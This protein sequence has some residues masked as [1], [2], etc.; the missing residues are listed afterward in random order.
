MKN[1][2]DGIIRNKIQQKKEK[3]KVP[4]KDERKRFFLKALGAA[5]L[6]AFIFSMFPKKAQA[7]IFGSSMRAPDPIGLKNSS[8]VLINPA[9]S[10]KQDEIITEL[11]SFTTYAN[12]AVTLTNASTAYLLPS[13]E[14]ASRKSI[15]IYNGSD[16]DMYIGSSSVTSSN[17]ALLPAGGVMNIDAESGVYATCASAG[18][19]IRV[20]EC[21]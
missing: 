14:Q 21:K 15:Q 17:G 16:T 20:M 10:E 7:L 8:G 1:S 6:S 13:S 19:I 3:G 4:V 12:T 9:T 2:F 5:G 11:S 18:K